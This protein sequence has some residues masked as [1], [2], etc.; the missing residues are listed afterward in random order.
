MSSGPCGAVKGLSHT[1]LLKAGREIIL[2]ELAMSALTPAA[3][4]CVKDA[5][6][7]VAV[8]GRSGTTYRAY[9]WLGRQGE[10]ALDGDLDAA[11]HLAVCE[12]SALFYSLHPED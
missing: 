7:D 11:A 6:N 2:D 10:R 8:E 4:G 3:R 9:E 12:A 1:D 5:L